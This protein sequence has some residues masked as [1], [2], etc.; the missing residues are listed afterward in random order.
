M[1]L[2]KG[3]FQNKEQST[4]TIELKYYNPITDYT[5]HFFFPALESHLALDYLEDAIKC[6]CKILIWRLIHTEDI[7]VG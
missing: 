7:H 2:P 5:G 3:E 6:G 4:M 1:T